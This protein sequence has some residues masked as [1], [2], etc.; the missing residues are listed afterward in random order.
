MSDTATESLL[1]KITSASES[2]YAEITFEDGSI[3]G[4]SVKDWTDYH[5]PFVVGE[6]KIE[7]VFKT[8]PS[9]PD[10]PL[11]GFVPAGFELRDGWYRKG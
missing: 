2:G 10:R 5:E 6:T 3:E 7:K 1:G 8:N 9:A 11:Y 4:I